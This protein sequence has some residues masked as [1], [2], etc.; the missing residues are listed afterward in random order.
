MGVQFCASCQK[1]LRRFEVYRANCIACCRSFPFCKKCHRNFLSCS[2]GCLF[3]FRSGHRQHRRRR[4][5][6]RPPRVLSS[7]PGVL[8]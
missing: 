6:G 3:D 8:G 5:V 1:P 2:E 4:P 7:T